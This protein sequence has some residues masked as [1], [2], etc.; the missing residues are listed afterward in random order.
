MRRILEKCIGSENKSG[1]TFVEVVVVGL[2]VPMVMR[3]VKDYVIK[4][5]KHNLNNQDIYNA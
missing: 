4:I 2:L 1:I 5:D 3:N